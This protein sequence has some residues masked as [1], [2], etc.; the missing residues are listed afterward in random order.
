MRI[1]QPLQVEQLETVQ[2]TVA[3]NTERLYETARTS[4]SKL[5]A[6]LAELRYAELEGSARS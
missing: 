2:R 4:V 3:S 6:E 1:R 5:D